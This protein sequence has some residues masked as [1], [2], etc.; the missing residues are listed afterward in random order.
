MLLYAAWCN[1]RTLFVFLIR[2][3]ATDHSSVVDNGIVT[4]KRLA[5][6][7]F[8]DE[9]YVLFSPRVHLLADVK[10]LVDASYHQRV[11][12]LCDKVR[13]SGGGAGVGGDGTTYSFPAALGALSS[14]SQRTTTNSTSS[15]N[16]SVLASPAVPS[17]RGGGGVKGETWPNPLQRGG[18]LN[19]NEGALAGVSVSVA[20]ASASAAASAAAATVTA[21]ATGNGTPR[22]PL[23]VAAAG[24]GRG[25]S[26]GGSGQ[27][28]STKDDLD[29]ALSLR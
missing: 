26:G 16:N 20:A 10:P 8:L 5:V 23:D 24:G 9:L 4:N 22:L 6:E 29:G 25:V 13:S 21:A 2:P 12:E 3:I 11:D 27:T 18:S 17:P 15:S 14:S 1:V 7:A 19:T 28:S